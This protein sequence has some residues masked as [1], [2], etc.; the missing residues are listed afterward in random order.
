MKHITQLLAFALSSIIS[1]QAQTTSFFP[2][3][4]VSIGYRPEHIVS[5]DLNNDGKSDLVVLFGDIPQMGI[6]MNISTP[7]S[8][9]TT[10]SAKQ[11]VSLLSFPFA[12]IVEDFDADNK[13]DIVVSYLSGPYAFSGFPNNTISGSTIVS[14]GS[15]IDFSSYQSICSF[16]TGDFNND[17][18][19]DLATVSI[20]NNYVT[21]YLNSPIS[22]YTGWYMNN[23]GWNI[24]VPA[25]TTAVG[26]ADINKDG[27]PDIISCTSTGII[28]TSFNYSIQ[29]SYSISF[30]PFQ[31]NTLSG[32][33]FSKIATA[34]IN[35]DDKTDLILSNNSSGAVSV[36]INNTIPGSPNA[37]YIAPQQL[38]CLS[39]PTALSI[40]DMNKDGKLDILAVQQS[41]S[42]NNI[43][44]FQNATTAGSST[45]SFA[46]RQDISSI[47]G[48][49]SISTDDMNNDGKSDIGVCSLFGVM[50]TMVNS[51]ITGARLASFA[52]HTELGTNTPVMGT[53]ADLNNDGKADLI[54]ANS[55]SNYLSIFFNST[56]PGNTIPVFNTPQII[57]GYVNQSVIAASDF[58]M[59]GKID[60]L[61]INKNDGVIRIITNTTPA[62]SSVFSYF[63]QAVNSVGNPIAAIIQDLNAD[64]KPD[65]VVN[66]TNG[67]IY[68]FINATTP[69][70]GLSF[71]N[72]AFGVG[73]VAYSV[74][75]EDINLDGKPDIIA[76]NYPANN[77]N[78][79]I[80][81]T[82]QG[83]P[84]FSYS[85]QLVIPTISNPHSII[86]TDFNYDGKPDIAIS[87][88][89]TLAILLNTTTFGNPN[90]TFST[91]V[92]FNTTPETVENSLINSDLN[93]D[94]LIDLA[95]ANKSNQH[96]SVF[97]N[98]TVPGCSTVSFEPE[99]KFTTGTIPIYLFTGDINNDRKPDLISVSNS[100]NAVSFLINAATAA[101]PVNYIS[102]T[103]NKIGDKIVLQWKCSYEWDNKGFEIEKS[104]NGNN[105]NKI[106]FVPSAELGS[107]ESSYTFSDFSPVMGNNYYRLRQV[108]YSGDASYSK[109]VLVQYSTINDITL[110]SC[111]PNPFK[112]I[113]TI[114]YKL[115]TPVF[116]QLKVYNA[117]GK[118]IAILENSQKG[119]GEYSIS[120]N[121][122]T[123]P[124]GI[125]IVQLT[126]GKFTTSEKIVKTN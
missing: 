105:W 43:C 55:V 42:G 32:A 82:S 109:Q 33:S 108:D 89:N 61:L 6:F 64:G 87:N 14:L 71:S 80:N 60:L 50:E 57:S 120:W 63:T 117:A 41:I 52:T 49:N 90:V 45:I 74:A 81:N 79:W 125:Y 70:S 116:V 91:R 28:S 122:G 85:Y 59:D 17:G 44:L 66:S 7:G 48:T 4:N 11:T 62:G 40:S 98:N 9:T 96:I 16:A 111:H 18:R 54:T 104:T 77:F 118:E 23:G 39:N 1:T 124:D 119:Q 25:N 31:S 78:I 51:T 86:S 106:G 76:A 110:Y 21:I 22:G 69:G 67:G 56:L 126:A 38:T 13:P 27:K 15:R 73:G 103:G 26:V 88:N 20:T 75:L 113:V 12:V 8:T 100:N 114:R 37:S 47:N 46:P 97:Q 24:P 94:G 2:P 93:G 29:G 65:I 102:F 58:T 107:I 115:P 95:I 68:V 34:D 101:L 123:M 35:N 53:T 84:I 36:I 83:Y 92:E 112:Q 10:Y 19:L 5:K 3:S 121:A 99:Q 30:S 72:T